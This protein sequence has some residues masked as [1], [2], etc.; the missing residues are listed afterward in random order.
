MQSTPQVKGYFL[1]Y[2]C[3]FDSLAVAVV[4]AFKVEV[5]KW[6][7]KHEASGIIPCSSY[8]SLDIQTEMPLKG[9]VG[10]R[11][12]PLVAE[13]LEIAQAGEEVSATNSN[14][15]NAPETIQL[16]STAP[17]SASSSSSS[18]TPRSHTS[19][20]QSVRRSSRIAQVPRGNRR[21][22]LKAKKPSSIPVEESDSTANT[23][24]QKEERRVLKEAPGGART[25]LDVR[26]SE[27]IQR[28]ED[29]GREKDDAI[30]IRSSQGQ[31]EA[32]TRGDSDRT[33]VENGVGV[34]GKAESILNRKSKAQGVKQ[35][36]GVKG[37]EMNKKKRVKV[38]SD[39]LAQPEKKDKP[40]FRKKAAAG[41]SAAVEVGDMCGG[42]SRT[43]PG[44]Q[45]E[46]EGKQAKNCNR[47]KGR[48]GAV[49][50]GLDAGEES[51]VRIGQANDECNNEEG[52]CREKSEGMR[53]SHKGEA[54]DVAEEGSGDGDG[55]GD[56]D[57]DDVPV[58]T[59]GNDGWTITPPSTDTLSQVSNRDD[60]FL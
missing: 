11:R 37:R 43:E 35:K 25:V 18:P 42:V 10:R 8:L 51:D 34:I 49:L 40:S 30:Q 19:S 39:D 1:I 59:E 38:A 12:Q 23:G 53:E 26:D 48:V 57:G 5:A 44:R 7:G 41:Q 28:S 60:H 32:V 4:T 15:T 55:I 13:W 47:R 6:K 31:G 17:L 56:G 14:F 33:V 29:D 54:R 24:T 46:T 16:L 58:G 22:G 45:Q 9:A 52:G 36:N 3:C 27:Y 2:F 50:V 20:T 21:R